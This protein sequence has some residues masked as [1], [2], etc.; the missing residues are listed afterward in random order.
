MMN[1]IAQRLKALKKLW[2]SIENMP[3][4][5]MLLGLSGKDGRFIE[6]TIDELSCMA[7]ESMFAP[8]DGL[9]MLKFSCEAYLDQL[10]GFFS[11]DVDGHAN[12]QMLSF[13]TLLQQLQSALRK[14]VVHDVSVDMSSRRKVSSQAS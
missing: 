12:M 3:D 11:G 2:Q 6:D 8:S 5:L 1:D 9:V 13:V 4:D 14:A 7:A 10:E